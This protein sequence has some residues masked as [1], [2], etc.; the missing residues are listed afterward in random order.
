MVFHAVSVF[1]LQKSHMFESEIYY[2][3]N[4][5]TKFVFSI[6]FLL[7]DPKKYRLRILTFSQ[8]ILAF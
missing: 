7:F 8:F 4:T 5:E 1:Q 2:G 6:N 3:L